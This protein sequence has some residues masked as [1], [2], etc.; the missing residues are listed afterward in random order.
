MYFPILF[1]F[2]SYNEQVL[3]ASISSLYQSYYHTYV[4]LKQQDPKDRHATS[5]R[6]SYCIIRDASI[7]LI[8]QQHLFLRSTVM[9][10]YCLLFKI[11][12]LKNFP[13]N[14]GPIPCSH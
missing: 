2:G 3:L 13:K 6:Y 12:V 10:F 11:S 8:S 1:K 14:F 5:I 9:Y 7:T 4:T